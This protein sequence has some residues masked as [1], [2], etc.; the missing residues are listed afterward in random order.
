MSLAPASACAAG[1]RAAAGR[2]AHGAAA[3]AQRSRSPWCWRRAGSRWRSRLRCGC[4]VA[5]QRHDLLCDRQ[6]AAALGHRVPRRPAQRLRA[7]AGVGHRRGGAALQP[8]QHRRRSAA[9]QQHYLFYTMFALCLAGL[10]GITITGDAFNIFVFLEISS[11]ST[12]VLIALGQRPA[13]AGG[14]VS[15]PD[16]GHDRRDLHRHRRR[17]AVPDDRHAEPGRHGAA[18]GGACRA[19]G[20][21]WRRWRS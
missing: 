16:H 2:A 11:L 12:Y 14:L 6:L 18:P 8:R 17:A 3:P 4:S 19:R 7:G 13:R 5:E 9:P 21:C 1:C 15:V 10:L 20:R